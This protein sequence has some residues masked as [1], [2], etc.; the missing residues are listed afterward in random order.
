MSVCLFGRD[1]FQIE[2]WLSLAN[3]YLPVFLVFLSR[4]GSRLFFD[5]RPRRWEAFFGNAMGDGDDFSD[6]TS[7]S[8]RMSLRSTRR[9]DGHGGADDAQ[10]T[11]KKVS[12]LKPKRPVVMPSDG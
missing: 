1:L 6:S 9:G 7:M 12:S 3:F 5:V 8:D 11:N 4:I 10:R 2:N